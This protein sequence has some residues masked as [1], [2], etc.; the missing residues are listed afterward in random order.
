M[1][2]YI[3]LITY[4]H[5]YMFAYLFIQEFLKPSHHHFSD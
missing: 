4:L 2:V 5:S 1:A 3:S